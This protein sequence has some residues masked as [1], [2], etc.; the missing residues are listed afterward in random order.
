MLHSLQVRQIQISPNKFISQDIARSKYYFLHMFL[1]NSPEHCQSFVIHWL[2][3]I[4]FTEPNL[5][6]VLNYHTVVIA[7]ADKY[8]TG[9]DSFIEQLNQVCAWLLIDHLYRLLN[10]KLST[11]FAFIRIFTSSPLESISSETISIKFVLD[12]SHHFSFSFFSFGF[13]SN[14]YFMSI[15]I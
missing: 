15:I 8:Q 13:S 9:L 4:N 11:Y 12:I 6:S 5:A 14:F 1:F 2:L 3:A 10:I 7:F